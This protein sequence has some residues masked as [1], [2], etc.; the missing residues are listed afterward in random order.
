MI[1]V[2]QVREVSATDAGLV[3]ILAARLSRTADRSVFMAPASRH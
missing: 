3:V 1:A 2:P